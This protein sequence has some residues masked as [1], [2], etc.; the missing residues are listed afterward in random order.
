[1]ERNLSLKI[2]KTVNIGTEEERTAYFQT[3]VE[4]QEEA[5]EKHLIVKLLLSQL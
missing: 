2:R 3:T 1:M 4:N 5:P